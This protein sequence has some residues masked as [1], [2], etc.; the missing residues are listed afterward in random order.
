MPSKGCTTLAIAGASDHAVPVSAL[1]MGIARGWPSAR[2]A[3]GALNER[4]R[5]D[6][7][8]TV[9]L[10]LPCPSMR[11]GAARPTL[12]KARSRPSVVTSRAGGRSAGAGR[13]GV[14]GKLA[15]SLSPGS[16]PL[17]L[18]CPIGTV[19]LMEEGRRTILAGAPSG[20]FAGISGLAIIG[21]IA[22][23]RVAGFNWLFGLP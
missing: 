11:P 6:G 9:T 23:M 19:G 8:S 3:P 21:S 20:V 10:A 15:V 1:V 12:G 4:P 18:A 13:L 17:C 16:A 22:W 2:A 7:M 5:R 14:A